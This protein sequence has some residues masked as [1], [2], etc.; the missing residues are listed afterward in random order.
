MLENEFGEYEANSKKVVESLRRQIATIRTWRAAPALIEELQVDAYGDKLPIRQLGNVSVPETRMIV[1]Q[2]CDHSTLKTIEKAL[3][4]AEPGYTVNN[5]GR[6]IRVMI[7]RLTQEKR[8]EL[9]KQLLACREDAKV[10]LR[11]ARRDFM[12]VLRKLSIAHVI[13][14]T[15]HHDAMDRAISILNQYTKEVDAIAQEKEDEIMDPQN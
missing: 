1:V 15:E 2:P 6:L 8:R 10:A 4:R 5:D 9:A 14:E 11:N 12:D 7:P 3:Q 13:T